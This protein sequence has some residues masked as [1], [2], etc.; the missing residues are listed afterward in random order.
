MI[1]KLL[2]Q[3]WKAIEHWTFITK[4]NDFSIPF[5]LMFYKLSR[6]PV[7][8][9]RNFGVTGDCITTLCTF[10]VTVH[11]TLPIRTASQG[12]SFAFIDTPNLFQ[13]PHKSAFYCNLAGFIIL[14]RPYV[15]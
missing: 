11:A 9:K 8:T 5:R 3:I 2:S 6:L 12:M 13:Y 14:Y 10:A 1:H 4:W 15:Y 7:T